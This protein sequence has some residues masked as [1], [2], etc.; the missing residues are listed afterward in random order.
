MATSH[1]NNR[2][3]YSSRSYVGAGGTITTTPG[4]LRR[5]ATRKNRIRAL[6]AAP[7]GGTERLAT[8]LDYTP[9]ERIF[10]APRICPRQMSRF[11]AR[12]A[13]FPHHWEARERKALSNS[14]IILIETAIPRSRQNPSPS[15]RRKRK[16][17]KRKRE[18][19]GE[20]KKRYLTSGAVVGRDSIRVNGGKMDLTFHEE[21]THLG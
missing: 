13:N 9:D 14:N 4:K 15:K 7:P 21:H 5:S 10:H 8:P 12:S 16:K 19:R 11:R 18:N 1:E 20:R 3:H 17:K 2:L 6:V